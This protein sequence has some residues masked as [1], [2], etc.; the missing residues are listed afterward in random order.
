CRCIN[1]RRLC[2]ADAAGLQMPR[3]FRAVFGRPSTRGSNSTWQSARQNRA[4]GHECAERIRRVGN[5]DA[6]ESSWDRGPGSGGQPTAP[7]GLGRGSAYPILGGLAGGRLGTAVVHRRR[8]AWLSGAFA[9]AFRLSRADWPGRSDCDRL[10]GLPFRLVDPVGRSGRGFPP[11]FRTGDVLR[12]LSRTQSA[13]TTDATVLQTGVTRHR[14][15]AVGTTGGVP[16]RAASPLAE[17]DG[18]G[19]V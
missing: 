14:S 8:G 5:A 19:A 1:R 11:R 6:A 16:G 13:R 4:G 9:L 12:L 18:D 15:S 7:G 10:A 17:A 2:L 3:P